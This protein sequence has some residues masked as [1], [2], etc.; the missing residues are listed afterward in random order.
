MHIQIHR[1]T[2]I[3]TRLYVR[4]S[5]NAIT[6]TK[7]ISQTYTNNG[8]ERDTYASAKFIVV[9]MKFVLRDTGM[10]IM[11]S[12]QPFL[13]KSI[14][15][16]AGNIEHLRFDFAWVWFRM[17]FVL[18]CLE[19][20][21]TLSLSGNVIFWPETATQKPSVPISQETLQFSFSIRCLSS[22]KYLLRAWT[23]WHYHTVSIFV[24]LICYLFINIMLDYGNVSAASF[25]LN[26]FNKQNHLFL[27]GIDS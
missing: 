22:I 18:F 27:T 6:F 26:V 5:S 23:V 17:V 2:H 10:M 21:S 13:A 24:H 9:I 4:N 15:Y 8:G 7:W 25:P 16:G 19:T 20:F 12:F 14:G 1:H 11:A 3:H